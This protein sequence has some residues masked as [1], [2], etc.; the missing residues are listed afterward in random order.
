MTQQPTNQPV[1]TIREGN[2]KATIWL[3]G[4]KDGE[5]AP[6]YSVQITRTWRDDKGDFHDSDSF[7]GTELLRVARLAHIAYDEIAIYRAADK[8]GSR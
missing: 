2:L 5:K 6:F 8:E 4:T 1:D 7:S 3:N